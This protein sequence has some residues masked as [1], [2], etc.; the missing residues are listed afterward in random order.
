[1]LSQEEIAELTKQHQEAPHLRILQ[2]KLAEEITTMVHSKADLDN[3]IKASN[4]LFG[5]SV[6]EELKSLSEDLFLE[7]FEGVPQKEVAKSEVLGANIVDL[8]SEKSGF[9]KSKSE[10]QRELKGNAIS[11]NKEKVADDFS[12]SESD[13]I[14]GK[15]LLLQKG[16]KNYFVIIA[17]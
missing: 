8:L 3:A 9:L 17:K 14:N 11:V 2:K 15:F 7:I 16:K 13:L 12:V 4:I 6:S 10:A 1:M 5:N